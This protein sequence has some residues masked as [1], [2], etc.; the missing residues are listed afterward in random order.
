MKKPHINPRTLSSMVLDTIRSFGESVAS[1]LMMWAFAAVKKLWDVIAAQ[2]ILLAFLAF[3]ILINIII[4]SQGLSTWWSE[5]RAANFMHRIG[6]GPNVMMSKAIYI[7]DLDQAAKSSAIQPSWP[8][9]S[10]W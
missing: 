5:R 2:H 3:S 9:D 7:A 6:V 10:Y 1:S 8:Q 4:S